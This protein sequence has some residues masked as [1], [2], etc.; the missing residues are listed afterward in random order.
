MSSP[1]I[2]PRHRRVLVVEDDPLIAMLMQ[3]FLDELGFACVG[4][5][6]SLPQALETAERETFEA[7]ILDLKLGG[8]DVYPVAQLLAHRGIPFAFASGFGRQGVES[9][10]HDRPHIPKPY[11]LED[12]ARVL[13]QLTGR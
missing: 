4:P 11:A 9:Y 8:D 13:G 3:D 5:A 6:F 1:L 12:V 2:E 7:G 10:W